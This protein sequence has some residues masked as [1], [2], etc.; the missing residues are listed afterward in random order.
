[1]SAPVSLVMPRRH[2][3]PSLLPVNY[4]VYAPARSLGG[5]LPRYSTLTGDLP[6]DSPQSTHRPSTGQQFR[7][8]PRRIG[9]RTRV[10]HLFEGTVGARDD[11]RTPLWTAGRTAKLPRRRCVAHGVGSERARDCRAHRAPVQRQRERHRVARARLRALDT[12]A[13]PQHG[14]TLDFGDGIGEAG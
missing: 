7:G 6:S 5:V 2:Y 10:I 1:Y 4:R 12:P 11:A 9:Y 14:V 13:V 3:F 8:R